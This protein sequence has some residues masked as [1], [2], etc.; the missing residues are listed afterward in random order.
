MLQEPAERSHPIWSKWNGPHVLTLILSQR[1][2]ETFT[3]LWTES[4]FSCPPFLGLINTVKVLSPHQEKVTLCK[5]RP[6]STSFPRSPIIWQWGNALLFLWWQFLIGISGPAWLLYPWGNP[7]HLPAFCHFNLFFLIITIVNMCT[8]P[9]HSFHQSIILFF[10]L[11]MHLLY[12][13]AIWFLVLWVTVARPL[14]FPMGSSCR[15]FQYVHMQGRE[16]QNRT[17]P[18]KLK[19]EHAEY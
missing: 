3:C 16:A 7:H 18:H 1:L 5:F 19:P 15:H 4:H 6:P 2:K 17:T 11:L 14:L 13:A 9:S 12:A 10:T 8:I